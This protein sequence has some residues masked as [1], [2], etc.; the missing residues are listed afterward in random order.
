M[1]SCVLDL[2]GTLL[3]SSHRVSARTA[4]GLLRLDELGCLIILASSRAPVAFRAVLRQLPP[5]KSLRVVA[6]QG[7]MT[8]KCVTN[9]LVPL[10][11]DAIHISAAQEAVSA[12]SRIA[13][14]T[15][16]NWFTSDAWLASGM[17]RGVEREAVLIGSEPQVANLLAEEDPPLKLMVVTEGYASSVAIAAAIRN[18]E[19]EASLSHTNYVE[20]TAL[21]IDKARAVKRLCSEAGVRMSRVLAVGDGE[22]DV[23]LLRLAGFSAAPANAS[24]VA[25]TTA[26][27]QISSNDDDGPADLILRLVDALS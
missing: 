21:G 13:P 10:H 3:D 1:L 24:P 5:L 17:D 9:R 4:E 20:I 2:D 11:T 7:A 27:W 26:E 14:S 23:G 15:P 8:A 22:N 18:L 19:L 16:V 6:A 12:I 25:L